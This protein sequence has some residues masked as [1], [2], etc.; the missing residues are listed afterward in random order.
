MTDVALPSLVEVA[1]NAAFAGGR[2]IMEV[3][4]GEFDV[5]LKSDRSPVTLADRRAHTAI[6]RE[7]ACTGL[8][9]LSEE[10]AHLPFAQRQAWGRYWLV[11]PLDGTKE[12]V[13]RNGEFAVNIALMERDE[14]PGGPLGNAKPIAGVIYGP[15]KD[16]LYFAWQGEGA[17][18]QEEAATRKAL[19]AY[20]R[21]AMSTRLPVAEPRAAYTIL[22][23]RS[24]RSPE[25][26]AFIQR[27]KEEHGQVVF[28]FLGSALKFGLMAEGA[29]DVYPRYAPTMEWD[30]AAGQII[31]SEAGEQ[32]TDVTTGEPMRYNKHELVNNWFIVQ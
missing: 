4:A 31:C 19:P 15:V 16:L 23:S 29:A 27:K 22:A 8:P 11:D 24:H 32:L 20:E 2:A 12:F 9:V 10:G 7:L 30:T 28:A 26:E 17:F 1:I 5:E 6:E 3:Y 13:K 25:T 14:L 21:V 18:R